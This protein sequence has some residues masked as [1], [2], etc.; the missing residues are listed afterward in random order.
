MLDGYAPFLNLG[1]EA[2][3]DFTGLGTN[4]ASYQSAGGI[5]LGGATSRPSQSFGAITLGVKN[6]NP[7]QFF[8]ASPSSPL[9]RTTAFENTP[10]AGA[11]TDKSAAT[12][13]LIAGGAILGLG[14]VMARRKA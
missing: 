2:E 11:Q 3:A 10:L 13:A 6:S 4:V 5:Q 12:M 14:I 7:Y 8:T 9:F 1:P